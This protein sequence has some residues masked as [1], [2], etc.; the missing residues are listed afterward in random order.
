M[1]YGKIITAGVMSLCAGLAYG[2]DL[3][4]RKHA[5]FSSY[6]L[7]LSWQPGFCLGKSGDAAP[8][9]CSQTPLDPANNLSA[10]GLWP[11]LPASLAAKGVTREEWMKD[12]CAA[13]PLAMPKYSPQGK[14]YAPGVNVAADNLRDFVSVMP[15]AMAPSCLAN[16]EWGKHGVCFEFDQN[17][18]FGAIARFTK[19]LRQSPFGAFLAANIGKS[20][21][22]AELQKALNGAFGANV[23]AL[24]KLQCNNKANPP[25][26][27]EVQISLL[28]NMINKPLSTA[29]LTYFDG[30]SGEPPK[31]DFTCPEQ[32]M[33]VGPQWKK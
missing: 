1:Q 23:A 4:A 24:T 13:G 3:K 33:I 18:Y 5:D 26:F 7:A 27:T 32:V 29:S 21:P 9:E 20:V 2:A 15:G 6:V 30:T 19:Q 14:C 31:D 17:D 25:H 12:G 11:S 8:L 28:S 16:Y 22:K 10:H